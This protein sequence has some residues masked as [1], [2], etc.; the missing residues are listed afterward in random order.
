MTT[1]STL[2]TRMNADIDAIIAKLE[3]AKN[4]KTYMQRAR[5]VGEVSRSCN[6]FEFYWDDKLQSLM[7]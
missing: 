2:D 3:Q 5:I 1:Y 7:D 6:D 4:A